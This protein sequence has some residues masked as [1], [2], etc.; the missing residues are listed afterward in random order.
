MLDW[1]GE[2]PVASFLLLVIQLSWLNAFLHMVF[3]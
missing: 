1:M 3:G 2:H